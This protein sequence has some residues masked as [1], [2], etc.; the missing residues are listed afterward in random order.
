MKLED[1]TSPACNRRLRTILSSASVQHELELLAPLRFPLVGFY[2]GEVGAEW[3]SEGR[4][5]SDYM[6]HIEIA[7]AGRRQIVFRG[8]VMEVKPGMAYWFPGNT[9]L[10]RRCDDQCKV[11][12][13]KFRCEWLPG[14]DPLLD[15]PER[16]PVLI[17]PC[18]LGYWLAWLKPKHNP[19]CSRLLEL[20][21]RVSEWVATV[22]PGLEGVI[23]SHLQTHARFQPVFSLIEDKLGANLRVE[24]LAKAHG[25]SVHAF[26]MAF[27]RDTGMS[28]KA[29]VKRRLNQEAIQL[30]TN[31]ELKLKQVADRL[32]FC[33]EYHFSRFFTKAN[34]VPPSRYRLSLVKDVAGAPSANAWRG[35]FRRP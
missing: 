8:E 24:E 7:L 32:S 21:A 28:P 10:E 29:Y 35:G 16:R 11:L 6:H 13:L 27:T 34:G 25:T 19:S 23:R 31:T 9:P 20:Q 17:G 5:E 26:S 14:V 15:W 4:L 12:F 22:I 33:D 3:S 1:T 18:D 30:L 2:Y